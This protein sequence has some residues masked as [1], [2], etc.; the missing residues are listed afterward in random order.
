MDAVD[1]ILVFVMLACVVFLALFGMAACV[2]LQEA[3]REIARLKHEE[4]VG[5][6]ARK[7]SGLD[8]RYDGKVTSLGGIGKGFGDGANEGADEKRE[9]VALG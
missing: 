9:G 6:L 7:F 1:W 4:Y 5:Y 2:K 3:R 8:E